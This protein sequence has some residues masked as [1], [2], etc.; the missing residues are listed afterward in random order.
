VNKTSSSESVCLLKSVMTATPARL[1]GENRETSDR[2]TSFELQGGR[3]NHSRNRPKVPC[4]WR[5]DRGGGFGRP[6]IAP[7][8]N[9]P[10]SRRALLPGARRKSRLRPN[11]PFRLHRVGHRPYSA[12]IRPRRRSLRQVCRDRWPTASQLRGQILPEL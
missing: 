5:L 11:E 2:G 9:T 1:R 7:A 6:A 4:H 12:N 10:A 3:C 8:R